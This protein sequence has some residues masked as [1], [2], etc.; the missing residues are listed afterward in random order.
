M[1]KIL[2]SLVLCLFAIIAFAQKG[3]L[4][5]LES[6]PGIY[7]VMLNDS[8]T[9]HLEVLTLIGDV[10]NGGGYARL[11][12]DYCMIETANIEDVVLTFKK[13]QINNI[14]FYVSRTFKKECFEELKK[15]YGEPILKDGT[16][17]WE[18]KGLVL[19]YEMDSKDA[20]MPGQAVGLFMRKQDVE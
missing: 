14:L 2:L 1:K 9:K 12:E 16:Y 13:Y 4:K 20:K 7:P 5:Y 11:D 10:K 15:L 6:R 18:Y 3:T 8:V 19:S 17:W